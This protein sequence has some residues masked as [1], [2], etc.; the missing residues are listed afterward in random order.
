MAMCCLLLLGKAIQKFVF[1]DLRI[2]EYNKLKD[3]FWNFVFY[4]FIFVFGIVNIQYM[5]EVCCFR[6][7]FILN[8][9]ISIEYLNE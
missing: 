2:T 7:H 9:Q 6:M 1:G 8:T 4:K 3:K 5:Q